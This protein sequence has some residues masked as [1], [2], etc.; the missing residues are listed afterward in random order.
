[1]VCSLQEQV[2][3]KEPPEIYL[4]KL[5]AYLDP[6]HSAKVIIVLCM[7]CCRW[8]CIERRL[9]LV[10]FGSSIQ[11]SRLV[12]FLPSASWFF[13]MPLYSSFFA[14]IGV[15]I[16]KMVLDSRNSQLLLLLFIFFNCFF[17]LIF[18]SHFQFS[19]V[20]TNWSVLRSPGLLL[21]RLRV[22]LILSF[23]PLDY[24]WTDWGWL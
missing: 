10:C 12:L 8:I 20:T 5:R 6:S 21:N 2:S 17:L 14:S 19:F 11:E 7:V 16:W 9:N 1:V 24:F 13:P 22:A 23:A 3:A 15:S 4:N 18:L